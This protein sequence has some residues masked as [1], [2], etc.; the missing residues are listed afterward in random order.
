MNDF[1]LVI[2]LVIKHWII[3]INTVK[4]FLV[5]KFHFLWVGQTMTFTSLQNNISL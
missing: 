4:S 1:K 5:I 3:N 2:K